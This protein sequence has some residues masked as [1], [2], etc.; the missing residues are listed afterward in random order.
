MSGNVSVQAKLEDGF[1]KVKSVLI[2]GVPVDDEKEYRVASTKFLFSGGD[3]VNAWKN[4]DLETDAVP[5]FELVADYLRSLS[6]I[7]ATLEERIKIS[8]HK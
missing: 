7:D 6:T 1:A 4:G 2:D 8:E 3:G 5:F